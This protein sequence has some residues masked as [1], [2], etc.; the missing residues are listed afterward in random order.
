MAPVTS[1]RIQPTQ[2]A[3]VARFGDPN[4]AMAAWVNDTNAAVSKYYASQGQPVPGGAGTPTETMSAQQQYFNQAQQYAATYGQYYAPNTPGGAAQGGVNAPNAGQQTLAGQQQQWQQGFS[5]EQLNQ[6]ASQQYLTLLSQLQ[7]PADYGKY[8]N[9]L[10]STPGGLQGM[11]SAAAGNY[12]PGTGST[13]ASPQG[14]TLQNLVGAAT[15]YGGGGTGSNAQGNQ[16]FTLGSGQGGSASPGGM[17]YQQYMATAQGLPTPNQIAPQAFGNMTPS[18][19]TA[20]GWN[21]PAAGLLRSRHQRHV[22]AI[23]PEI[24]CWVGR[25]HHEAG[26][27]RAGSAPGYPV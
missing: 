10:G 1:P 18:A 20:Y 14:Q 26:L 2:Q 5:Q 22:S 8:L 4:A 7:G 11:V 17:N 16:D 19:S 15:G 3:Y 27:K 13:G 23:A 21:V 6:Q 12:I 24:R 25:R 9:V